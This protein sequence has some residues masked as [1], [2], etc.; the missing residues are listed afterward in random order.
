[1]F[2]GHLPSGY[3]LYRYCKYKWDGDTSKFLIAALLG[4]VFPD[5]DMFYFYLVDNRMHSHHSYWIHIPFYWFLCHLLITLI[6]ITI[7]RHL[8]NLANV[9]FIAI[10]IH[11]LLDSVAGG[12][13][14]L[15]P[16]S[17]EYFSLFVVPSVYSSWI[18]NFL[19]HWTFAFE[20][21]LVALSVRFLLKS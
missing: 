20:L 15:Y 16:F 17:S 11:L 5:F 1:M 4:S 19:L 8:I 2:I 14:W 13:L 3:L 7:S 10:Y 12:I 21:V 18:L 9:F 6:L